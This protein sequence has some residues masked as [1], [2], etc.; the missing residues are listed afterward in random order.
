MWDSIQ[1]LAEHRLVSSST[2]I[3]VSHS[4]TL[5]EKVMH[6][7][8]SGQ[9]EIYTTE[10]P[11]SG[12]LPLCTGSLSLP[13]C[14]PRGRIYFSYAKGVCLFYYFVTKSTRIINLDNP[15]NSRVRNFYHGFES[16]WIWLPVCLLFI[17]YE[18]EC[19]FFLLEKLSHR[20]HVTSSWYILCWSAGGRP[21]GNA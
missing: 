7:M 5:L 4:L 14:P 3:L 10:R 17:I 6:L 8:W 16:I 2:F 19:L 11:T 12:N 15:N 21:K 9:M 18:L 1:I 20:K 13:I